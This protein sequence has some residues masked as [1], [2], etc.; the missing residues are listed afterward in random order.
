MGGGGGSGLFW[1]PLKN[2]K[3]LGDVKSVAATGIKLLP[4]P[5]CSCG[6]KN[7]RVSPKRILFSHKMSLGAKDL[8]AIL[9]VTVP[10]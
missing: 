3:S 4:L 8:A 1:P 2:E 5:S 7:I 10:L 9:S 6:K